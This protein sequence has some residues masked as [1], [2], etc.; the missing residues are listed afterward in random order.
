MNGGEIDRLCVDW[1]DEN[2]GEAVAQHYTWY[3][4]LFPAWNPPELNDALES[5]RR[6]LSVAFGAGASFGTTDYQEARRRLHLRD[7]R[8]PVP[9][10]F[11]KGFEP[12][13]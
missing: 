13:D 1:L 5:F 3:A 6:S 8:F 2:R 11:V 9:E 12:A 10:A 7:D 4:L